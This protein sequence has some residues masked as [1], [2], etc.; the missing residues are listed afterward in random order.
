MALRVAAM[1]PADV[2]PH[3]RR[4]RHLVRKL[5]LL[6]LLS[7]AY[8]IGLVLLFF[9]ATWF[10]LPLYSVFADGT[11]AV[12]SGFGTRLL[13]SHRNWFIRTFTATLMVLAGL[14]ILG[15]FSG[16][17]IG[18][19][20]ISL[21]RGYV[22]WADLIH[23]V[24]GI[25]VSW[26]ALWAWFRPPSEVE[27]S[28][29]FEPAQSVIVPQPRNRTPRS[30]FLQP[31]TRIGSSLGAHSGN[32]S[33]PSVHSRLKLVTRQPTRPKSRR[34]SRLHRP[35]VQLAIVEEHRCPYCLEPVLRTDPRGVKECS[36]CHTLH[37]ADCWAIT[38]MC[39]VPHLNT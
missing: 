2:S 19:D 10:P 13:L 1:N 37:H 32:G 35:H 3:I 9:K 16:W 27:S 18:I 7:T 24:T 38:G 22:S 4:P 25:T 12:V 5:V 21:S 6:L 39:Q 17:V 14:A 34:K 28:V 15:Y 8:A 20:L 11:L 31:R 33:R 30:W 23:L 29:Y 26:S 36:V